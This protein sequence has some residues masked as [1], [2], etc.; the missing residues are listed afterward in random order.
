MKKTLKG[1]KSGMTKCS[2]IT[3][4]KKNFGLISHLIGRGW[5]DGLG[6]RVKGGKKGSH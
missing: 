6:H 3:E 4:K 1:E 5:E 2:A